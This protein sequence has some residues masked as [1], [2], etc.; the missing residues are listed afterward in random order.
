[1]TDPIAVIDDNDARLASFCRWLQKRK[2]RVKSFS[3]TSDFLQEVDKN[4]LPECLVCNIRLTEMSGL[5]LRQILEG[6]GHKVPAILV[7]ERADIGVAVSAV[8]SGE[9]SGFVQKPYSLGVAQGLT[10]KEIAN[11]LRARPGTS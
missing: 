6:K 3:R 7:T 8:R 2:H 5:K 9:A 10:N 11:A 1:M 4:A